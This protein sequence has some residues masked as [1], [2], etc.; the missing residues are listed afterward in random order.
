MNK[1]IK[2]ILPVFIIFLLFFLI[3]TNN[4]KN[5]VRF[6]L[7]SKYYNN[8]NAIKM[9]SSELK[10]IENDS[11]LLFTYNSVCGM[12]K[13]CE[14]IFDTVLKEKKLDYITIPFDEFRKT[15]FHDVVKY[16]PSFIIIKNGNIVAYLDADNDSHLKFYQNEEDFAS[17]LEGRVIFDKKKV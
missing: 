17:W 13:P 2:Y 11:F 12:A 16:A 1:V 8:G 9:N 4:N 3:M 15:K 5:N 6:Y 10:K 14:E 7:E